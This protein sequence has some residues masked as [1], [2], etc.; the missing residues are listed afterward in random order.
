MEGTNVLPA[1]VWH[2]LGWTVDVS[3]D[4]SGKYTYTISNSSGNVNSFEADSA[5]GDAT[6]QVYFAPSGANVVVYVDDL[7]IIYEAPKTVTAKFV[8]GSITVFSETAECFEGRYI[9]PTA[10][11][12]GLDYNP[13]FEIDGEY[14][15][16]TPMSVSILEILNSLEGDRKD[17]AQPLIDKYNEWLASQST[18]G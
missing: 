13:S 5:F 10:A 4:S 3:K 14:Q 12:L 7:S 9:L 2:T 16:G 11:E 6:W 1:D 18:E 15:Y 8:S 17:A